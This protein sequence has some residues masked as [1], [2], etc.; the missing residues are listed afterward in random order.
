[1]IRMLQDK[2]EIESVWVT[3]DNTQGI[4]RVGHNGITKIEVYPEDSQIGVVTWCAIYNGDVIKY[5]FDM[6]GMGVTYKD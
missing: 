2:R 5:R 4:W 3:T 6:A 1:M